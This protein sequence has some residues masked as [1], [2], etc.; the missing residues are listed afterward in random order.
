[1]SYIPV[2]PLQ[3]KQNRLAL[4]LI[5]YDLSSQWNSH[6]LVQE[7]R[8]RIYAKMPAG[9]FDPQDLEHQTLFRLST[10]DPA[11]ITDSIIDE[12]MQEQLTIITQRLRPF[13]KQLPYLFRGLSGEARDLNCEKRLEL[14]NI[15]GSL[16]AIGDGCSFEVEFKKIDNEKIIE[17]FTEKLHYI[18]TG[19]HKGDA[20]GF[21][22]KGDTMPWGVET[23]E[24][25]I[26][27]KQYKRDALLAHGI[28]P[29]KAV[30][31]TRL[32]LLPGSPTNSISILD[33]LVSKHY[34][35]LGM[36]AMHTTTMP[37]Y[38]KTKGATTAGGMQH[39]LLVKELSHKFTPLIIEGTTRYVH[40]VGVKPSENKE[41][42]T[43]HPK[44]PTL[45][46]VETF[47]RLN[48]NREVE[49]LDV[50]KD[51]V[52]F[53]TSESRRGGTITKETKFE[54]KEVDTLLEQLQR[55][56]IYQKTV[57]LHDQFW[58]WGKKPKLRL[59]KI[60]ESSEY[61]ISVSCKYRISEKDHVRTEVNESLYQG[62]DLKA[63]IASITSRGKYSQE[64]SYEKIR[65]IY[66]L[67][68]ALLK[69][70][71]CPFGAYLEVRGSQEAIDNTTEA[72]GLDKKEGVTATADELY[73][74]WAKGHRLKNQWSVRFG[75]TGEDS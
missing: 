70:D 73:L 63:A 13:E 21:F 57:Y 1:M 41:V 43:T 54:I 74:L 52:I 66:T 51:K 3:Q 68:D 38:A 31:I 17:L 35:D 72:L 28:D 18:H 60:Y 5:H 22:F 50:L 7:L 4:D 71:L 39:V 9:L 48:K 65:L 20:F 69:V 67:D 40:S 49:P 30:E 44:F 16:V 29:H 10:Y 37:T 19:R 58:G 32:Y 45:H 27:T 53:I 55:T 23:I 46:T 14:K 12:V 6:D 62:S 24:P 47:M 8:K 36:E 75:L 33:G 2:T 34:R 15:R 11:A 59:R 26:V 64:N 25:S 42:I 56:A 61:T